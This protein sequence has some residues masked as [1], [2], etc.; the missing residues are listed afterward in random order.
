MI[1]GLAF[2]I[3]RIA[4]MIPELV[5]LKVGV[6]DTYTDTG[7]HSHQTVQIN[8]VIEGMVRVEFAHQRY[9]LTPGMGLLIVPGHL[10][11]ILAQE[12]TREY[13]THVRLD[14][15]SSPFSDR[16]WAISRFEEFLPHSL[17][18]RNSPRFGE[19]LQEMLDYWCNDAPT[20]RLVSQGLL[21]RLFAQLPSF[22]CIAVERKEI[23]DLPLTEDRTLYNILAMVE[24]VYRDKN[25]RISDIARA[26]DVSQSYL[27]K[28]FKNRVGCGPK[29]YLLRQ[30][31]QRAMDL[32]RLGHRRISTIAREAGF[33]DVYAF[34]RTFKRMIGCAPSDYI[35]SVVKDS[36]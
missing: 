13:M 31:I 2:S 22:D 32:M 34:S 5:S 33:P 7:W 9:E 30:R 3:Q 29:Q 16:F 23:A 36:A 1:K 24:R 18:V 6:H 12:E 14:S 19:W 4:L 27:Y 35:Q 11:R 21:L 17:I 10:H 28:L 25:V 8:C 26:N 15:G 20:Q